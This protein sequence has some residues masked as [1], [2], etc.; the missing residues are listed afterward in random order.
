M[1]NWCANNLTVEHDDPAMIARLVKAYNEDRTCEE[2]LPGCEGDKEEAVEKWGTK[3]D[4]GA[5]GG[6]CSPE[7]EPNKFQ[8]SFETA[9]SP[10]VGLYA[11]LKRL[12]YRVDATYFEP[13]MSFCGIWKDGED[14]C[15]EYKDH[16]QIPE[17]IRR[18][19]DT[20]SFFG[21]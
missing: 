19:Y 15:T 11:E 6:I 5:D 16:S 20:D 13:G 9:W 21:E 17:R 14:D 18:E 10:P 8:C 12:G 3:W 2:F 7:L 1:P 4:F